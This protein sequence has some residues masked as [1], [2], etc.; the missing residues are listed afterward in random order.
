MISRMKPLLDLPLPD[1]DRKEL[2]R[3]ANSK[4][5]KA[6]DSFR[7]KIILMRSSGVSKRKTAKALDA[8]C[9]TVQTWVDRHRA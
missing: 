5:V 8:S 7:A 3:R 1:S 4:T 2:E 6:R 9:V